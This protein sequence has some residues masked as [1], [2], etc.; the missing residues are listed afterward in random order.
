MLDDFQL[1][2][3]PV[4]QFVAE[5]LPKCVWDFIPFSFLYD[6]YRAWL[7]KYYPNSPALNRPTFIKELR[8]LLASS[9]VWSIPDGTRHP[10]GRMNEPELLIAEYDLRDWMNPLYRGI[11]EKKI[12]HPQLPKGGMRGIERK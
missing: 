11:D 1:V 9:P 2:N 10:G 4:S 6:L 12:C 5:M 7:Q 3:D 8:S